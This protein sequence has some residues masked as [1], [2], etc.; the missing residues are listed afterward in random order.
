[1]FGSVTTELASPVRI[2]AGMF[3]RFALRFLTATFAS[4]SVAPERAAKSPE[5][6]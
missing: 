6:S 5:S 4:L 1:M 3:S 2:S